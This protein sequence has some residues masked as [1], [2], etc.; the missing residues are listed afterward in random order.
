M[1]FIPPLGRAFRFALVRHPCLHLCLRSHVVSHVALKVPEVVSTNFTEMLI[2][3]WSCAPGISCVDYFSFIRV[4]ALDYVKI[5][6]TRSSK[7]LVN[8]FDI[9]VFTI[10]ILYD[11]QYLL[12]IFWDWAKAMQAYEC[13]FPKKYLTKCHETLQE[14]WSA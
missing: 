5:C 14:Y 10:K 7:Y 11:G 3:M 9:H 4:I 13:P 2:S 8:L 1:F 6:V 12:K